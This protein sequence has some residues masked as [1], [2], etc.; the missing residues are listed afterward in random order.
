MKTFAILA[1]ATTSL[2][3]VAAHANDVDHWAGD[4]GK[5]PYYAP[6]YD[7]GFVRGFNSYNGADPGSIVVQRA[8]AKGPVVVH[9][10]HRRHAN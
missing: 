6:S 9:P 2:F 4:D 10:R 1:V 8:P 3:G 5:S 7:G